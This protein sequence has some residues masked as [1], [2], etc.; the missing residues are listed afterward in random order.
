M[1][2][3]NEERMDS[4]LFFQGESSKED[5]KM[6]GYSRLGKVPPHTNAGFPE[7]NTNFN[8]NEEGEPQQ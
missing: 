8:S 4:V 2:P 3:I 1:E 6:V 5:L 7:G